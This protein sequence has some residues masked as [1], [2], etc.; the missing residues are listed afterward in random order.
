[1]IRPADRRRGAGQGRREL[2]QGYSGRQGG[3]EQG[4]PRRRRRQGMGRDQGDAAAQGRVVGRRS[5]RSPNQATLYDH[6]RN[7][8]VRKHEVDGKTG[9]RRRRRLQ[10]RRARDRGRIRMAVP[11]ACQHGAGLRA[12]RDQGRP[13]HAAGPASQKPHFVPRRR[14]RH[15]RQMPR[16][17]RARASGCRARAPTAATMPT[18]PRWMPRCLAKA[19]G[20]PVRAAIY[21]RPRHRLG[22][23]RPGLD[24]YA[25]A[26]RSMRR[27]T[28]LLTTS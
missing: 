3:V 19:V 18:T 4:L 23:E 14:R 17:Q 9:R 1:M 10:D 21:A 2:D 7:A 25:C 13:G 16:G 20:K 27:A 26:P 15:A 11:V 24:P 12:G 6:I 22:S 5:R 28:S 8:P